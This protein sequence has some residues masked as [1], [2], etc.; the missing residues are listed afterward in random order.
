[1]SLIENT[2]YYNNIKG[3][4]CMKNRVC[5]LLGIRYP[6][7][8]GGLA[9]VGNGALAAAVSNGGGF[10]VVGSAGRSPEDFREQIR[11]ASELTDQ[12]FGANLPISEHSDNTPYIEAVLENAHILKGVS[13]S[14]GNP[15]PIIPIFKEA[16][17]KVMVYIGS[18]K[19]ALKAEQIGADLV[20]GEGFEAGGHN[21]P[22]E[23]TLFG[24]IPQVS[25]AVQIPVI[26]AGGISNGQG[27]VAAMILGAE[28]IQMGTRFVATKEC[29]A[30]DNY[31]KLLVEVNDDCTT[32]IARSMGQVFRVLNSPFIDKVKEVEKV[33]PTVEELLPYIK[34]KN[35]K[36]AAIDGQL[37]DGWLNC[38]QGVG[39]I[40][41]IESATDVV[42]NVIKEA[43]EIMDSKHNLVNSF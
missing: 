17:L 29:Q 24:L 18:V 20:I 39:L 36:L 35:N 4:D 34:G 12:P 25:R 22:L 41:S 8:Q 38:G 10:G 27:M 43:K 16:G 30:H 1:M 23:L 3:V 31:K 11:I 33:S 5:E 32:V 40:N 9:Y 2:K 19:H 26:A 15:K 14:A 28:G 21:S 13:V 6:V 7:I 37:D 42:E